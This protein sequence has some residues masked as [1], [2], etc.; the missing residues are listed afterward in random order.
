MIISQEYIY[1]KFMDV[2]CSAQIDTDCD[3][4]TS[5][6]YEVLTYGEMLNA[7]I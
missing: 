1:E 5:P 3:I 6:I 7:L 2:Y 4:T